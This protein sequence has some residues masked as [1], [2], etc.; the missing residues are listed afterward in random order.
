V[1]AVSLFQY[2][3]APGHLATITSASENAF[4]A[5]IIPN[6]SMWIAGYEQGRDG[7]WTWASGP[8]IN[9]SILYYAWAP[10][11]NLSNSALEGVVFSNG[12]WFPTLTSA[13]FV[14]L[15]EYCFVDERNQCIRISTLSSVLRF[16]FLLHFVQLLPTTGTTT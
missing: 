16:F 9:M 5:Q 11:A 8:E 10:N 1:A 13:S 15:A 7:N 3:K 2:K 6:K 14:Y 12:E 4:L